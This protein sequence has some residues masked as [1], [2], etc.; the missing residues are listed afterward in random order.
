[1]IL[2]Y[3]YV[4][5]HFTSKHV[6][7]P[8][9]VYIDYWTGE[10]RVDQHRYVCRSVRLVNSRLLTFFSALLSFCFSVC[11]RIRSSRN[12]KR[13]NVRT[14][15]DHL[16]SFVCQAALVMLVNW[17]NTEKSLRFTVFQ[18][19]LM[20]VLS[21]D[22]RVIHKWCHSNFPFLNL[23]PSISKNEYGNHAATLFAIIIHTAPTGWHYPYEMDQRKGWYFPILPYVVVR[24]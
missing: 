15:G 3:F 16:N 14:R 24:N 8:T 13:T 21:W 11:E 7:Q 10:L 20:L 19:T 23:L 6:R 1:M 12:E 2:I 9:Y 18:M 17:H 4:H 5:C 22:L